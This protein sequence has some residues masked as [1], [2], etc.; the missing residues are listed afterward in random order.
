MP[1]AGQMNKSL[2]TALLIALSVVPALAAPPAHTI[3]LAGTWVLDKVKS[4]PVDDLM[5]AEG[6]SALERKMFGRLGVKLE[7]QQTTESITIKTI[8]SLMSEDELLKPDDS[9]M[10]RDVFRVGPVKYHTH[11]SPDGKALITDTELTAGDGKPA[12]AVVHRSLADGGKTLVQDL[13]LTLSDK[14][15]FSARRYYHRQA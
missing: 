12:L 9:M 8:T 4:E 10:S 1:E 6:L 3:K 11:W 5:A 15:S 14:R 2:A 13:T 7:I